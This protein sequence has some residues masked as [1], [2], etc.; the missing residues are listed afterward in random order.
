M[1]STGGLVRGLPGRW[2]GQQWL[3]GIGLGILIFVLAGVAMNLPGRRDA[4]ELIAQDHTGEIQPIARGAVLGYLGSSGRDATCQRLLL[5]GQA[6]AVVIAARLREASADTI[7]LP[8]AQP[9]PRR[10]W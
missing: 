7:A 2:R 6:R 10:I 4:R 3:A 5:N 1:R 8:A 9:H